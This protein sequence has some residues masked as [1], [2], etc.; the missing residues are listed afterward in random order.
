MPRRARVYIPGLPYHVVQRGNNREACFIEPENYQFYLE[1]WQELSIRYGVAVHAYCL[2]T[3]HIHFLVTPSTK[4][5]LSNTM[6]VVGSRYAQYINKTY[7]R[8]GTL[9]EGRH[10]ASLVQAECYLFTTMRYIEMN[11]VRAN[12]V[13]RPEEYRWSSYGVNAWGDES[14]LSA[15]DQ[16]M[17]LGQSEDDRCYAYRELFRYA[18]SEEDLH[19]IRKAAHYCQPVGDDRFRADIEQ[20]YGIKLGEMKRGRPKKLNEQL[21]NI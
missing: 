8:T 21:V 3:N 20:K 7:R 17:R 12:M 5:A 13:S 18:L 11:P 1:L 14:W 2:M 9:W 16:Y 15:H 10:R 19:F 4:T 6:K